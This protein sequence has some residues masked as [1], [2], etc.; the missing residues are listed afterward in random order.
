MV[1]ISTSISLILAFQ[2][3]MGQQGHQPKLSAGN[4]LKQYYFV[5]LLKGAK[6]DQDSLTAATL[7]QGHMANISR[8]AKLGKLVI[9]GPFA[10]EGDWRGIF[11]FDCLTQDEVV[12]YLKSDPAIIAGRLIY[13]IHPWWTAKNCLFK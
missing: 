2:F 1:K 10:D 13:E 7:Q 4:E 9:A 12:G 3:L 6:R 5:M 11:I 8:L